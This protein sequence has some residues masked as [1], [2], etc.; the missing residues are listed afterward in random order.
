MLWGRRAPQPLAGVAATTDLAAA[1]AAARTVL[2]AIPAQALGPFLAE[3]AA[4]LD[5]RVLVSC[6][7]GIDRATLTG[8]S[9]LIAQPSH[10]APMRWRRGRRIPVEVQIRSP[11]LRHEGAASKR[12]S[13]R[14]WK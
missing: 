12:R 5:G 7:K 8:P 10:G 2:L 1:L 3:N 11:H 4:A 14:R 9:R 6:A 13:L